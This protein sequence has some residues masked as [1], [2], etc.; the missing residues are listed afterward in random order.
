M[1]KQLSRVAAYAWCVT[2][3]HLLLVQ[4]APAEQDAGKWMLPGGGIDWGEHPEDAMHRELYEETGLR[5]DLI[6]LMHVDSIVSRRR[7]DGSQTHAIR[8]LYRVAVAIG[9]PRLIDVDGSTIAAAWI[10]LAEVPDLEKVEIVD[11][12]VAAATRQ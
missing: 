9:E 12:A 7:R 6:E 5:G 4:V 10:P 8:F 1:D 11:I 3:N 2:D